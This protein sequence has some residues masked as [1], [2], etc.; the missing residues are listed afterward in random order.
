M[1]MDQDQHFCLLVVTERANDSIQSPSRRSRCLA[2]CTLIKQSIVSRGLGHW[3]VPNCPPNGMHY[4]RDA[5]RG[6]VTRPVQ[7]AAEG[8]VTR[9]P[10]PPIEGIEY[11]MS[12]SPQC[13]VSTILFSSSTTFTSAYGTCT[14]DVSDSS[15][16]FWLDIAQ[17]MD[18]QPDVSSHTWQDEAVNSSKVAKDPVRLFGKFVSAVSSDSLKDIRPRSEVS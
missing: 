9:C 2:S 6:Q 17:T 7:D 15:A 8:E 5:F 4:V 12:G 18:A 1:I 13:Q 11:I 16:E 3:T 14:M 10:A